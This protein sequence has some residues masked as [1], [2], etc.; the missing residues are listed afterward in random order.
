MCLAT[1]TNGESLPS[2]TLA[3]GGGAAA[4]GLQHAPGGDGAVSGGWRVATGLR[5]GERKRQSH[6]RTKYVAPRVMGR[7]ERPHGGEGVPRLPEGVRRLARSYSARTTPAGR[8]EEM[9]RQARWGGVGRGENATMTHSYEFRSRL[10]LWRR[11][12]GAAYFVLPKCAKT[13][14]SG[15]FTHSVI[16]YASHRSL[17]CL[18]PSSI[19]IY[20]FLRN[21]R[22]GEENDPCAA[23]EISVGR[24]SMRAN[25]IR[26]LHLSLSAAAV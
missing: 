13:L 19:I 25:N 2:A 8:W 1:E 5:K 12:I 20:L 7:R 26:M 11:H 9:D 6:L 24:Y 14:I 18:P 4:S 22:E 16:W 3:T 23:C 10:A 17:A 15:G 21:V